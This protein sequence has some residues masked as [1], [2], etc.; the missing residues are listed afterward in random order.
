MAMSEKIIF[1][2]VTLLILVGIVIMS[3]LPSELVDPLRPHIRHS[4][5]IGHLLVYVLLAGAAMLSVPRHVLTPWK[6][7]S[8]ALKISLL[9]LVVELLQPLFGRT[10][11]IVDFTENVV[12]T[13]FG[14]AIIYG[15]LSFERVRLK[16]SS[17]RLTVK[18]TAVP[19]QG[20]T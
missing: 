16:Y 14:M 7:T 6:G 3:F 1:K 10:T 18:Q 20:C 5:D 17:K 19:R 8:I 2:M 11:S 9:G 15:Y 13:I 12:G 4:I